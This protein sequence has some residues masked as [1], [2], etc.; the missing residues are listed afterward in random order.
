KRESWLTYEYIT[1]DKKAPEGHLPL[2]RVG[3]NPGNYYRDLGAANSL[4]GVGSAG[5]V[6]CSSLASKLVDCNI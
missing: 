5:R 1:F 2:F 6:W 4:Y 3:A